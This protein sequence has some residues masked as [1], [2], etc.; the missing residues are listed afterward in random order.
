MSDQG[1]LIWAVCSAFCFIDP[2]RLKT[3]AAAFYS[4][5]KDG[6]WE[7]EAWQVWNVS[8]PGLCSLSW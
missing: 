2:F 6:L 3:G 4:D 7:T 1:L 5:Q 8:D